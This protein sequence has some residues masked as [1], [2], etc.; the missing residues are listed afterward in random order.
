MS[1]QFAVIGTGLIGRAWAIVF[2][3]AGR[4]VRLWDASA[5][6]LTEAEQRI[7]ENLAELEAQGLI[8]D[9]QAARA[10]VSVAASLEDALDGAVWMQESVAEVPEIKA[11]LFA[12]ADRFAPEAAILA[13]SSSAI[14][15][16]RF[17]EQVAG[18]RRC[19]IAHPV[20]PP[21]LIPLV[22]LCPAPWTDPEVVSRARTIMEEVAMVPVSVNREVEGFVLNRLQ[23]ALLAEAFR[24]VEDGVVSVED[25]D[26]TV[27]DGLGLRWSFMGPFETIDLNAPGGLADYCARYGPFYNRVQDEATPREWTDALVSKVEAERRTKLA[28][29]E[30]AERQGW[31]DRRLMALLRAKKAAD[32]DYGL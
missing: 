12:E 7:A 19:L 8:E 20:N 9:A 28:E 24:L 29:S 25:V 5:G 16:S 23:G 18:R 2:A 22:E 15:A 17:T 4:S 27:R 3:R 1:G 32:T 10:R 6:S 26:R 11:A 21:S 30:L 13:S 31:R 14:A